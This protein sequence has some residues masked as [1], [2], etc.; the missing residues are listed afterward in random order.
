RLESVVASGAP[1]LYLSAHLDDAVFSCG[2]L[3]AKLAGKCPLTVATVFTEAAAPPHTYAARSFLRQCSAADVTTL[4]ADRRAEDLEVL[5][6]V[7]VSHQHFGLP[8]A[9]FRTRE[10]RSSA[11]GRLGRLVPELVHLYPTYR[12]DIARGRVARA[13]RTLLAELIGRVEELVKDLDAQLVFS[14]IGVGKHVD[15]LITRSVGESLRNHVIYYSDFPYDLSSNPD[16][17]FID[18][19]SLSSW[20]WEQR[21]AEKGRWIRGY[22]TQFEAIFAD[23]EI[24]QKPEYYYE[25]SVDDHRYTAEGR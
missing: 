16:S 10:V 2:A 24:T 20:T 14:P 21:I 19:H 3:I 25:P 6:G 9:L 12:F 8:D 11:L 4:Y 18:R 22:R 1:I 15:H 7:G 13:D 5:A 17:D 23:G